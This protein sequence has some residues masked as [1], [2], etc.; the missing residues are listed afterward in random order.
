[1]ITCPNCSGSLEDKKHFYTD[2]V[3][4]KNELK[5]AK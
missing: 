3:I 5:T 1:M 2:L 4:S